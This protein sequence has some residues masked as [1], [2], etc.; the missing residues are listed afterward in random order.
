MALT[1]Q[2][3]NFVS[4]LEQIATEIL[5]MRDRVRREMALYNAA[6]FGTSITDE[7]LTTPVDGVAPFPHLTQSKMWNCITAFDAFIDALGDD[8]SGQAVNLIN[9]TR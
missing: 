8:V 5:D 1:N 3:S 6:G 4:R 9:M 7:D 2:E